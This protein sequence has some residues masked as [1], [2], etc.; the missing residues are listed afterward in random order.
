VAAPKKHIKLTCYYTTA[1]AQIATSAFTSRERFDG[2]GLLQQACRLLKTS[3]VTKQ[4]LIVLSYPTRGDGFRDFKEPAMY[5]GAKKVG[6]LYHAIAV[7]CNA[8]VS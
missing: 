8:E 1:S 4:R 6:W 2:Y 3:L 7:E 5:A